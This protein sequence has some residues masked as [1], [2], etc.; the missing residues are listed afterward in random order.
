MYYTFILFNCCVKLYDVIHFLISLFRLHNHNPPT[1]ETGSTR[2]FLLGRTDT[3]RSASIAS[4]EFVKAMVSPNKTVSIKVC[5]GSKC[6]IDTRAYSSFCGM[7][8][9]VIFP[10][11]SLGQDARPWQRS[12]LLHVPPASP[13]HQTLLELINLWTWVKSRRNLDR[14]QKSQL[15]SSLS[16]LTV[17]VHNLF[18]YIDKEQ[19]W[20]KI[21]PYF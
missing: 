15:H 13:Q 4:S 10:W 3:I 20:L 14:F 18:H 8:W 19:I 21:C 5:F 17:C 7:K 12:V 11:T 2:K 16:Q 9:V 1:Y 6:P